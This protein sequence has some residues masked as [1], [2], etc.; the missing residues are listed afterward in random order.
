MA[1]PNDV[2]IVVYDAERI[3]DDRPGAGETSGEVFYAVREEIIEVCARHGPTW[4]QPGVDSSNCDYWVVDDQYNDE[5]YQYLEVKSRAFTKAWLLDLM[6]KLVSLPHWGVGIT[7]PKG[8]VIVFADRVMVAAGP[9]FDGV[10]NL[11]DVIQRASRALAFDE[12]VKACRDDVALGL[13]ARFPGIEQEVLH[14]WNLENA[15]DEGMNFLAR[16]PGV[17]FII[18]NKSSVTH[19]GLAKLANLRRLREV[20]FQSDHVGDEECRVFASYPGLAKLYICGSSVTEEGLKHLG[21]LRTLEVLSLTNTT[22]TDQ[23]LA[24]LTALTELQELQLAKTKV[25]DAGLVHLAGFSKLTVLRLE[26]CRITDHG[27]AHLQVLSHLQ[28]LD[29][30][31]TEVTDLGLDHISALANLTRLGLRNTRVTPHGFERMSTEFPECWI[32]GRE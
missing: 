7:V 3:P 28:K 27:L 25:T 6:A 5:R 23:G 15:T 14:F 13:L 19:R 24:H 9:T 22:I 12:M 10:R 26:G 20:W 2:P 1:A 16:M 30:D 17:A 29:L 4:D 18:L 31:E 11:N 21:R 8:Y 32:L